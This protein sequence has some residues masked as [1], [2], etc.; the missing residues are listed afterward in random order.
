[1]LKDDIAAGATLRD[2]NLGAPS[3]TRGL[4]HEHH[5]PDTTDPGVCHPDHDRGPDQHLCRQRGALSVK[6]HESGER[7]TQTLALDPKTRAG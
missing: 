4:P 1:M 3:A 7:R 5:E 2:L 6:W